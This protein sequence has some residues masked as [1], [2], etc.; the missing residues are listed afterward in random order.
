MITYNINNEGL[1]IPD[2][3]NIKYK[4]E[5]D[6]VLNCIKTDNKDKDYNVLKRSNENLIKEWR[7]HNILYNLGLFKPHTETVDFEYPQ[8]WYYKLCYFIID[9]LY[10]WD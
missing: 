9:L 10:F 7:S 5:M 1:S 4:Y 2:S 6:F 3:W 8:K